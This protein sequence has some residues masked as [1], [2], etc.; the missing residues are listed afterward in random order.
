VQDWNHVNGI[1]VKG[2][3][4]AA[5]PS[6]DYPYSTIEKQKPYFKERGLD[7]DAFF[8]GTLNISITP[9][10]FELLKP[11]FTILGVA[12]TDLHPPEHF[13]FSRCT[14]R[15]QGREHA[16]MVYYPHPETKIRHQQNP[17]VIEV[18]TE[19]IPGI[20]YGD[21]VVLSLNTIEILII[22]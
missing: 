6:N 1:V 3:R 16:G 18:M 9:L 20:S 14:I 7:L 10:R 22:K 12:W 21:H 15:F 17:G 8:T 2:H 13:S 4:V 5:R 11:E 19:H